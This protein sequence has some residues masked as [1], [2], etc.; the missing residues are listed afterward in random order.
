MTATIRTNLDGAIATI[1]IARAEKRNCLA[2]A[3]AEALRR[4]VEQAAADIR[5]AS[6]ASRFGIP[7][8]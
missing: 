4:A 3:D 7:A 6:A 5:L 2:I 8:I 1:T